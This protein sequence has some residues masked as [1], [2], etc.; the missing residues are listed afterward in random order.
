M[1]DISSEFSG[2]SQKEALMGR[3]SLKSRTEINILKKI[4]TDAPKL[5]NS[6]MK[7]V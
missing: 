1:T 2:M 5:N 6:S 7:S 4:L 3:V